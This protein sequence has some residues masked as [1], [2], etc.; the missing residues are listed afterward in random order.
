MVQ[1]KEI[2]KSDDDSFFNKSFSPKNIEGKGSAFKVITK[3][4]DQFSSNNG[5]FFQNLACKHNPSVVGSKTSSKVLMSNR[6][7][8]SDSLSSK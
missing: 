1:S 5:K 6:S 3:V 2:N 7:Y 4:A 8:K